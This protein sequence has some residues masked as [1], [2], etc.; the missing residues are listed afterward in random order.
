M[1]G[2]GRRRRRRALRRRG[3]LRRRRCRV[4]AG[5]GFWNRI[6]EVERVCLVRQIGESLVRVERHKI[7]ISKADTNSNGIRK[8]ALSTDY[9]IVNVKI[10]RPRRRNLLRVVAIAFC[11]V[12]WC[13]RVNQTIPAVSV[14]ELA[15]VE[16]SQR[17]RIDM[18]AGCPFATTHIQ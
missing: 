12:N 8:V 18:N 10:C 2:V 13:Y 11:H 5:G 1:S 15:P 14:D 6:A 17:G 16:G 4:R 7:G 3:C 9:G